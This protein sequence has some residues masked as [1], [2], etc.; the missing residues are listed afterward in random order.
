MHVG[1][2]EV[3]FF[4]YDFF[5]QTINES[6]VL[7]Q[8]DIQSAPPQRRFSEKLLQH[9][10]AAFLPCEQNLSSCVEWI[11]AQ[12][13]LKSTCHLLHKAC[14]ILR[15]VK[16]NL[17][18]KC[19]GIYRIPCECEI[20]CIGET[21]RANRNQT[22]FWFC[23][24]IPT[25]IYEATEIRQHQHFSREGGQQISPVQKTIVYVL[26]ECRGCLNL[27]STDS[28]QCPRCVHHHFR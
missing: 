22:D 3:S 5:C 19:P 2:H 6:K 13:I 10:T 12:H 20:V 18:L 17:G 8:A 24:T 9:I 11:L 4:L 28:D 23:H 7:S 1:L 15:P 21:D 16:D 26:K 14:R 27:H 25:V